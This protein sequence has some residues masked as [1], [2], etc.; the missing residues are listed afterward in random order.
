MKTFSLQPL[1][2][3]MQTRTDEATR[4]LGQ[5]LAAE[6]SQRERL[7]MLEQYREEYFQ[8]LRNASTE[9]LTLLALQ[10][11]QDF[12]R[13]IDEAIA[14]QRQVVANSENNTLSAQSQWVAQNKQLKAIDTL[15]KRHTEKQ[16]IIESKIEQKQQDEF[17]TRRFA[18][19]DSHD[20]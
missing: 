8:R 10:N 7:K 5:Q 16:K 12:I 9:G 11:Y 6:H 19:K 15:S 2:E 20:T 14:Q 4:K 13:R 1:L 17:V 3:L 18:T